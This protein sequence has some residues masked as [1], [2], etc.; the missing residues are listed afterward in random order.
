MCVDTWWNNE[1]TWNNI[2]ARVKLGH[3]TSFFTLQVAVIGKNIRLGSDSG[4][5][6]LCG[7]LSFL[8]GSV[9]SDRKLQPPKALIW[10]DLLMPNYVM[11]T[12]PSH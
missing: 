8:S 9:G 5:R 3:A 11:Y 1:M 12:Q 7:L 4:V 6:F 2:Q 10:I